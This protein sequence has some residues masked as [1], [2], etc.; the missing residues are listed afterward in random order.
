M[1]STRNL[2]HLPDID[3]LRKLSKSLAMLDAI[4]SPEWESRY[5]SFNSKWS[6]GEEMAS[7]RNGSGDEYFLLFNTSGAILKG[8]AHE[9]PMTPYKQTPSKLWEGIFDSVPKEFASFLT[10]PAFDI[11]STTFC[12]WRTYEDKAWQ[13]GEIKFPESD[14]PDGS[15]GLL[16]ILDGNPETYKAWAEEYYEEKISAVAVRDIYAHRPMT[17]E[18]IA[19]LNANLSLSELVDDIEEIGWSGTSA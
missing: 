12:I 16:F 4:I 6:Q 17:Y 3:D 8:F 1:I 13:C 11:E 10:E 7:M 18:L 5:Y 15:E 2:T 9:S 19:G 14:D